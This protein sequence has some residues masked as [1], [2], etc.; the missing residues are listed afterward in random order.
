[1]TGI[2]TSADP[3]NPR[4]VMDVPDTDAVTA[5]LQTENGA[6]TMQSDRV[7]AETLVILVEA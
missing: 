3:E 1:M 4:R 7:L 5:A 6:A 2:R